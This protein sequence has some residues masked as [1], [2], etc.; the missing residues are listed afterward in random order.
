MVQSWLA[1]LFYKCQTTTIMVRCVAVQHQRHRVARLCRA[2]VA[3]T[4]MLHIVVLSLLPTGG[5]QT[6]DA[7]SSTIAQ[8]AKQARNLTHPQL[9]LDAIQFGVEHGGYAGLQKARSK[10][11]SNP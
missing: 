4:N 8:A 2:L 11:C 9:C 1:T 3:P 5:L 7:S 10:P 6:S